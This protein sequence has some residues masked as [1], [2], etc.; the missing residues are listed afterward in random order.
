MDLMEYQGKRYLARWGLVMPAG[1]IAATV[2]E[3]LAAALTLGCWPVVVKA[4]VPVGGRG[5]AGGV[6]LARNQDDLTRHAATILGMQIGGHVVRRVWVEEA[7][8]IAAEHYVGI[9]LDRATRDHLVMI[10]ARG[11]VDIEEVARSD[12]GAIARLHVDPIDGLSRSA[13]DAVVAEAGLAAQ[14]REEVAR[15]LVSLYHCFVEGDAELLEVNPL[16]LTR[17]GEVRC[18]DAKVS[19]DD[20]AG[21]RHPEWAELRD[22]VELDPRERLARDKG[23]NYIGLDGNVGIIANGAGLAMATLD[24]VAEVGGTAANFLDIGGGADAS[25]MAAALEVINADPKVVS[26]LVN[27]FGGITRCDEVARGILQALEVVAAGAPIVLRLDGTNAAEGRAILAGKG[28]AEGAGG[29]L[30]VSPT[31]L[32]AARI[33]VELAGAA[34]GELAGAGGELVQPNR[35][36][37]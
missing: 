37:Q 23:L 11:G 14:A 31:M 27:I 3:A 4:Q 21:F 25:V 33:A 17:A 19:L 8:E 7:C 13:A 22:E 29:R 35:P 15:T 30:L 26:I 20:N 34:G 18:L 36:A 10:S 24:V 9:T 1:K 16:V 32:E 2:P 5:K 6:L 28:S 12:P